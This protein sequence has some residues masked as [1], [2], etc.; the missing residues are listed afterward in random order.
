MLKVVILPLAKADIIEAA[1]WYNKKQKGLGKRFTKEIKTKINLIKST[2]KAFAIRYDNTRTIRLNT[3]P[4]MIHY[5]IDLNKNIILIV[6]V[7]HTSMSPD[8]WSKR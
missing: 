6:A 2:P 4:F 3:F 5:T 7:Y 1:Y 8:H